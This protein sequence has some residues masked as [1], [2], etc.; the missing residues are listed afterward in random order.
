MEKEQNHKKI[1]QNKDASYSIIKDT[2]IISIISQNFSH[3]KLNWC[4]HWRN[5]ILHLKYLSQNIYISI[6]RTQFSCVKF[7]LFQLK[8]FG[9]RNKLRNFLLSTLIIIKRIIQDPNSNSFQSLPM[10]IVSVLP[11]FD[12]SN[13]DSL[14]IMHIITRV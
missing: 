5:S 1:K 6:P 8:L 13:I 7:C 12:N 10:I 2:N 9:E 14:P 4:H 11:S 3:L